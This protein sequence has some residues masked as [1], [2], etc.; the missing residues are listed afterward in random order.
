M[1]SLE[2]DQL[3]PTGMFQSLVHSMISEGL[4]Q[5]GATVNGSDPGKCLIHIYYSSLKSFENQPKSN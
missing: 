5:F 4:A 2:L 3:K 1:A